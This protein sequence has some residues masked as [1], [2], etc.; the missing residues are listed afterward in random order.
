MT[1]NPTPRPPKES[2]KKRKIQAEKDVDTPSKR[3]KSS[4]QKLE[5]T[6]S[7]KL[8]I[9]VQNDQKSEKVGKPRKKNGKGKERAKDS[10]DEYEG[11]DDDDI[12]NAYAAGKS[13]QKTTGED[14]EDND[15]SYSND[16]EAP[17]MLIHESLQKNMKKI[18]RTPKQKYVPE[19][20]SPNQR[21]Q[22]TIFVGNLPIELA[23]KKV[24]Q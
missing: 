9:V 20:E 22:R 24:S 13:I 2:S 15:K 11:E 14:F 1:S 16:D 7:D 19:D 4:P 10:V 3:A 8:K 17:T 18:S 12:E 23:S 6:S 5:Q 21:D